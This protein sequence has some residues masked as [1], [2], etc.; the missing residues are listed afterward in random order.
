MHKKG[1]KVQ[2]NFGYVDVLPVL[3][4]KVRAGFTFGVAPASGP[5]TA[6]F[7]RKEKDS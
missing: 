3:V 4:E 5:H 7:Q 2:G 6:V 1:G